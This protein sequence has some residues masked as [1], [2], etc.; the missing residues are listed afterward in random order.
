MAIEIRKGFQG[1]A[2]YA[3]IV[4]ADPEKAERLRQKEAEVQRFL[5]DEGLSELNNPRAEIIR[6]RKNVQNKNI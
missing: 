1:L 5:T 2:A 3:E 6:V 4:D